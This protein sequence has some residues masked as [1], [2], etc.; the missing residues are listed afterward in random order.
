M[1]FH[2]DLVYVKCNACVLSAYN[3]TQTINPTMKRI[4]QFLFRL[5]F[6]I[7]RSSVFE[8]STICTNGIQKDSAHKSCAPLR[9]TFTWI[10]FSAFVSYWRYSCNHNKTFI[11]KNIKKLKRFCVHTFCNHIKR[12]ENTTMMHKMFLLDPQTNDRKFLLK[13]IFYLSYTDRCTSTNWEWHCVDCG[14][15]TFEYFIHRK[16]F[17]GSLAQQS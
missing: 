14:I 16:R 15:Y 2:I 9:Q 12:L 11:K 10:T 6:W 7:L 3:S 1:T 13:S 4:I 8:S 17:V 5:H